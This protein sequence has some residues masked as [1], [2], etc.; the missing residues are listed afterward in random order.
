MRR[1]KE[2]ALHN[3]PAQALPVPQPYHLLGT[4]SHCILG[5]NTSTFKCHLIIFYYF[6]A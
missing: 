4:H 5:I 6:V 1:C 3:T 2:P